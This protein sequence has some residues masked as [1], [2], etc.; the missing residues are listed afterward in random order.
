MPCCNPT[1]FRD[2]DGGYVA[3]LIP[4][5]FG[6]PKGTNCHRLLSVECHVLSGNGKWCLLLAACFC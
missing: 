6:D 1:H 4:L 5:C 3:I 2:P